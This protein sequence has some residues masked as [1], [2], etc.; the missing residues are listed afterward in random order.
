MET[1][2]VEYLVVALSALAFAHAVLCDYPSS[3]V[4]LTVSCSSSHFS[5]C[6]FL[7]SFMSTATTLLREVHFEDQ[8]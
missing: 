2:R 8:C 4:I 7:C 6:M 5:T 3:Q 1:S